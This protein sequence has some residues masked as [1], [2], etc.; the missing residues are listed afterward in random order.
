MRITSGS[1]KIVI[2]ALV[3]PTKKTAGPSAGHC[4]RL[5]RTITRRSQIRIFSLVLCFTGHCLMGAPVR[6]AIVKIDIDKAEIQAPESTV[7]KSMLHFS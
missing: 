7:V 6:S 3:D 5:L 4:L 2:V 1:Q